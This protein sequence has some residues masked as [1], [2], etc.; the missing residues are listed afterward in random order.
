VIRLD[1]S[2]KV[3][4]ALVAGAVMVT[5]L[6]D[7]AVATP[8]TGVTNVGDVENTILVLVVPVVPVAEVM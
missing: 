1:P 8:S 4:V 3:K 5:L 2:L 7:V 6:I